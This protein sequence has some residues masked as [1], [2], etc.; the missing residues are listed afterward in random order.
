[1]YLSTV[2]IRLGTGL[3]AGA[4]LGLLA[5]MALWRLSEPEH[6]SAP[7]PSAKPAAQGTRGTSV[8]PE[9]AGGAQAQPGV[10]AFNVTS[11]LLPAAGAS[12]DTRTVRIGLG[13]VSAEARARHLAWL[14]GGAQGAGPLDLMELAEVESWIEVPA[15]L[16]SD[17]RVRV[18]PV[19]LPQAYQYVLEA[20]GGDGLLFYRARFGHQSP[21]REI[22][23]LLASGLRI[24]APEDAGRLRLQLRRRGLESESALWQSIIHQQA[25]HLRPVFDEDGVAV[26]PGA[27]LL[28][29]PPGA[30]EAVVWLG[31]AVVLRKD[32]ALT[33]GALVTLRVNG[34]DVAAA[35]AQSTSI[36]VE[37]VEAGSGAPIP[38][39]AL[40]WPGPR[41]EVSVISDA[42]GRAQL[43][44]TLAG[45][46]A[47]L[48]LE[49]P[50]APR[51]GLPTW[52]VRRVVPI[53]V[54][55]PGELAGSQVYREQ[56]EIEPIQWLI[57]EGEGRRSG[58][59]VRG[60]PFP[61]FMLQREEAGDWRD[62]GADHFVGTLEGLAVSIESPGRYR[63]LK[64]SSPWNLA[65]TGEAE[66]STRQGSD[67]QRVS[68]QRSEAKTSRFRVLDA[69][70]RALAGQSVR[71]VA[72]ARALPDVQLKTDSLGWVELADATEHPV[73]LYV[74]GEGE[75]RLSPA[76]HD[77]QS[78]RLPG[79]E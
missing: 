50:E 40:T 3:A 34:A 31:A 22:S 75:I 74:E 64:A 65:F 28:P 30:F 18:G 2:A 79:S 38:D 43:G 51:N 63:V 73:E 26:R 23:P 42:R 15:E 46:E 39:V 70:G 36:E 52:P 29:L 58:P 17:G 35:R 67:Q 27:E 59:P 71:V 78:V 14:Q 49:F 32:I 7:E 6:A 12:A 56:I 8:D 24:A 55:D 21:P 66:F 45:H 68:L 53:A 19:D 41:G 13:H 5:L 44:D 20:H 1:M 48:A 61:V 25:P 76:D 57:V 4:L 54:P 37:L 10:V 60:Q 16:L 62:L 47:W 33:P 69:D 72:T 9:G 77:G 11:L